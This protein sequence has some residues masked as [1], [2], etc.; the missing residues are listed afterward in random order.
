MFYFSNNHF[1]PKREWER[2]S[3]ANDGAV[4]HSCFTMITIDTEDCVKELKALTLKY[5]K[6][7]G[8]SL[9]QELEELFGSCHP[10]W[11]EEVTVPMQTYIRCN[12]IPHYPLA[13]GYEKGG[14]LL[15]WLKRNK[16]VEEDTSMTEFLYLM[17]CAEERP[18]EVRP[19]VWKTNK[20][21]LR[22]ML[23]Y[24]YAHNAMTKADM[25]KLCPMVFVD[26]TGK[27]MTLA[28]NK[29]VY[30]PK[31]NTLM[32]FLRDLIPHE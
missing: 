11:K 24:I 26:K 1:Q 25:E 27:R 16:Y 6:E 32:K 29:E 10:E 13:I 3:E 22:K 9:T 2:L 17:G 15:G 30:D 7:K 19:I 28:K 4:N 12:G 18:L 20:Q 21:A 23:E 31:V 8:I 5:G 14:E